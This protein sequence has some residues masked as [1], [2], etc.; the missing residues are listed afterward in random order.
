[1]S[2]CA[3]CHLKEAT[4]H[5]TP[6]VEGKT[7]RTIDLCEQCAPRLGLEFGER[8]VHSASGESCEFCGQQ[9]FSGVRT[10]WGPVSWCFSCGLEFMQTLG[11]MCMAERPEFMPQS[12]EAVPSPELEAWYDEA[13]QRAVKLLKKRRGEDGRETH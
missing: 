3:K 5:F 11:Q 1:M 4:A 12:P 13:S 8:A 7:E 9:A 2:V 6:V 10:T